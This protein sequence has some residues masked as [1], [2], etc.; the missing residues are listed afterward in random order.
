LYIYTSIYNFLS[1]NSNLKKYFFVILLN[2]WFCGK[3]LHVTNV[4]KKIIAS[5]LLAPI[6]QPNDRLRC[7]PH[8]ITHLE[9]S[10][11]FAYVSKLFNFCLF[12]KLKKCD[13]F[14][15]P[16]YDANTPTYLTSMFQKNFWQSLHLQD[17]I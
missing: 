11:F 6:P 17:Y 5:L 14:S 3:Q 4:L 2:Q 13:S 10:T 16:L 1:T 15:G 9:Y 8:L 12:W 7:E